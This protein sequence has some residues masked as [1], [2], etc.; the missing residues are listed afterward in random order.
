[1]L[2]VCQYEVPLTGQLSNHTLVSDRGSSLC[3]LKTR[4]RWVADFNLPVEKICKII[5]GGAGRDK[6]ASWICLLVVEA[7][8][9]RP[10]D[11]TDSDTRAQPEY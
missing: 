10:L 2:C 9:C 11:E 5:L 6:E 7:S 4:K 3:E 1:M 8:F